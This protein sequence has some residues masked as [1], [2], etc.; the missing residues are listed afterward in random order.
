MTDN[1]MIELLIAR[2]AC[3]Y[4]DACQRVRTWRNLNDLAFMWKREKGKV[5]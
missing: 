5:R 1:Q 3:T 4:S 2:Y